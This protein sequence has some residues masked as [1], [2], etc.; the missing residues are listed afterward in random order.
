MELQDFQNKAELQ[1]IG[2]RR[3]KEV[4]AA[5]ANCS[6]AFAIKL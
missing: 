5:D 4:K 6:L 3:L 1:E 2:V